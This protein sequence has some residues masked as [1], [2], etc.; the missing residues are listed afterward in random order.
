MHQQLYKLPRGDGCYHFN[1]TRQEAI[2]RLDSQ[3]LHLVDVLGL[4]D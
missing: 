2:S 4:L 3:T 1:S